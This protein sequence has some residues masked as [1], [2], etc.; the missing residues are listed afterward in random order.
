MLKIGGAVLG[1]GALAALAISVGGAAP[2]PFVVAR[3]LAATQ[4]GIARASLPRPAG[5]EV[6]GP[7][8]DLKLDGVPVPTTPD[9][10]F[11]IGF[12][13][14]AGPT[15]TLSWTTAEGRPA[16]WPVTVAPRQWSIDH[17]PARP[18]APSNPEADAKWKALRDAETAAF[19]GAREGISDWP[20]WQAPVHPPVPGRISGVY[21][22]QRIWGDVPAQPHTGLDIAAPPGTPV[23]AP[24]PGIV[25]LAQG[26]FSLEGNLIILDHGMGLSTTYMHLSK[27]L[28][29]PGAL[30]RQGEVIGKVGATGRVTGPHL[31]WGMTLREV[32]VDPASLFPQPLPEDSRIPPEPD[33]P[34]EPAPG[35][36][37]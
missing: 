32:R 16:S 13:R 33:E 28:V 34:A 17:M 4:G 35:R 31:H 20:F 11:I 18:A 7:I 25:R 30:V 15:A 14:D 26:P 10:H 21:G 5:S 24:L 22:S 6:A 29:Q 27:I 12:A 19:K 8:T 37:K 1:L 9:G 3:P 2:Q 23:K 36:A